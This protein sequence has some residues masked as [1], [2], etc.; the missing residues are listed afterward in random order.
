MSF[1]V[2]KTPLWRVPPKRHVH[3]IR[4]RGEETAAKLRMEVQRDWI[5]KLRW[6]ESRENSIC[7]AKDSAI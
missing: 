7:I 6:T 3:Y 2:A 1:R 5:E 4:R